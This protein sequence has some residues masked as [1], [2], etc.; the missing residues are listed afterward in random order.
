MPR[1]KQIEQVRDFTRFYTRVIGLLNQHI[2]NSPFSLPEA[3][4]L[5]EISS[6]NRCTATEIMD[7]LKID[8]GY[9]SRMLLRFEKKGLLSRERSRQDGRTSFLGL[10]AKG[11]KAFALLNAASKEQVDGILRK[12]P[13]DQAAK[14]IF[15]MTEIKRILMPAA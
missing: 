9:L 4:V 2:L 7:V 8:R 5:F 13:P 1:E 11:K 15:H 10:T 6:R 3:R 12:L 14:L